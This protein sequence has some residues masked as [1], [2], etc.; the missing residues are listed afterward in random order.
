MMYWET[1]LRMLFAKWASDPRVANRDLVCTPYVGN[2]GM[3]CGWVVCVNGSPPRG[4]LVIDNYD[5]PVRLWGKP[6]KVRTD[7]I[8]TVKGFRDAYLED[9]REPFT[10]T[11]PES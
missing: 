10:L 6:I 2:Y 11:A 7:E 4:T 3:V 1:K 5:P 9:K 8:D